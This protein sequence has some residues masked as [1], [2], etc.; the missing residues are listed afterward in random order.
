MRHRRP[1]PGALSI[2]LFLMA[3]ACGSH[4]SA[5]TTSGT[6]HLI[7]TPSSLIGIGTAAAQV[8]GPLQTAP[9]PTAPNPTAT[10]T[11]RADCGAI[12]S[13]QS[14]QGGRRMLVR[15]P[16]TTSLRPALVMIHGYTATTEGEEAVSGWTT[17]FAG[18]D[19]VVAY[20][21]GSPTPESGF[22]W[23]TGAGKLATTG[24]DDVSVILEA[25]SILV[26][27]DCVDPS[28]IV[29]AGESNGSALALEVA[30]DPR[31]AGKA[32]LF[33]L[34][35]P[36]VD[37]NVLDRCTAARPFRL[38][39]LAGALDQTVPIGGTQP[40]TVGFSAPL[41][42]VQLVATTVDG[43][44]GPT[45][46]NVPDAVHHSYTRC[47]AR[48]DYF[49]V[50]DGHHTWPGGPVGAGGLDPGVFP[51]KSVVWCSSGI[52]V[53]PPPADCST[54]LASYGANPG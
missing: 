27:Q 10:L 35:I 8:T 45:T 26:T 31:S 2:V 16:A 54:V 22:G 17:F 43:C 32:V 46:T 53:Q 23:S 44:S 51:G 41:Q 28:K 15:S 34:A 11:T 6:G 14:I 19:T 49:Q 24:T 3:A 1:V 40:G 33:A 37:S 12:S 5:S 52:V 47:T 38:L 30:C 29:I 18:T 20:P 25:L 4:S 50:A 36:A 48:A 13:Y 21:E 9:V 39:V 7:L 42:W